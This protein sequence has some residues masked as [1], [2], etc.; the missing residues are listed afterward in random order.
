MPNLRYLILVALLPTLSSAQYF[1]DEWQAFFSERSCFVAMKAAPWD[2][3]EVDF[4]EAKV[5]F[6]RPHLKA[7]RRVEDF[8]A[9]VADPVILYV[10]VLPLWSEVENTPLSSVEIRFGDIKSELTLDPAV[11]DSNM[12]AYILG[13]DDAAS[14]WEHLKANLDLFVVLTYGDVQQT[15]IEVS[16]KRFGVA[17]AMYDA[18]VTVSGEKDDK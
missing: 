2:D 6:Y 1:A 3:T 12:P 8:P 14:A 7:E 16:S 4:V 5:S 15:E 11:G 10:Q 13:G 9:V 17:S 18:C